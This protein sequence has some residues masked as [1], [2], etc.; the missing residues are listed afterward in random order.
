MLSLSRKMG[1]P[2]GD[3]SITLRPA[4]LPRG[5]G[6][7]DSIMAVSLLAQFHFGI[8]LERA[9][10]KQIWAS[11]TQDTP[12]NNIKSGRVALAHQKQATQANF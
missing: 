8:S 5:V 1:K 2:G 11:M 12:L 3:L 7:L 9:G 6:L 4:W 10:N